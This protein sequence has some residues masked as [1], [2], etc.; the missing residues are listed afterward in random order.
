MALPALKK[1]I[2]SIMEASFWI[3]YGDVLG[4]SYQF[5]GGRENAL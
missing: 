4:C 5:R 3:S 2:L 1:E